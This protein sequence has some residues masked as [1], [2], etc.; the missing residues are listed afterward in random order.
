[1][2]IVDLRQDCLQVL[3][4]LAYRKGDFTL[5]SGRKLSLIHI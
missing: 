1:M 2:D 3:K 4:D 5:S